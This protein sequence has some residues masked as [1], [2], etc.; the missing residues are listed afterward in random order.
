MSLKV[1]S[2]LNF[3]INS[4]NHHGVHSPFVFDFVTKSLYKKGDKKEL[5]LFYDY[6]KNLLSNT[7][8]IE[9]KDFGAGSKIF[10]SNLRKVSKI[11]KHAGISK[12][13][14]NLLFN[15]IEYFQ[16]K[17]IL[18]IGTSLGIS[19][20]VLS[21]A[22]PESN[23]ITI[24]GCKTTASIAKQ[25]FD[26]YHLKNIELKIGDFNTS[27]PQIFKKQKFD[28]IYFDGNHTRKAT[29]DYFNQSLQ[30]IHN[31]SVLIFD[32]IHWSKEMEK[33]W[34]EIKAHEITKVTIDTFQWGIV[35]FRKEQE[36]EHFII[37]V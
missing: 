21:I 6:R 36:K 8:I 7:S 26:K 34:E 11:A 22:A 2:Y 9:V 17:N 24:E 30:S 20:S 3:V 29:L 4:K 18:E 15:L 19:T 27:L 10:N 32:D 12:K 31:D 1:L 5:K 13:R 37:R 28:L 23:I 35:F 16:P 25:E 33:A 14:G